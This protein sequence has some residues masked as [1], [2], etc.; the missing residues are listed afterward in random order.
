[1]IAKSSPK[2]LVIFDIYENSTY[3][4]QQELEHDFP[5]LDLVTLIGSVC[6]ETRV[7]SVFNTYRPDLVFHAAA[8]WEKVYDDILNH[9]ESFERYYPMVRVVA[10]NKNVQYLVRALVVNDALYTLALELGA[11]RR[12]R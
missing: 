11:D 2:R 5:S 12:K 1:M 3:A 9:P 10:N 8:H 6:S 4:I 7:R